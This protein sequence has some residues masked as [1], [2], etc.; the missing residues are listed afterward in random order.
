MTAN[1]RLCKHVMPLPGVALQTPARSDASIRLVTLQS[2]EKAY[3]MWGL[4]VLVELHWLRN[5]RRRALF[6]FK[7]DL[8]LPQ[9]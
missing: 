2:H 6:I 9:G 7:N 3:L 4:Q 5:E 8:A 1:E